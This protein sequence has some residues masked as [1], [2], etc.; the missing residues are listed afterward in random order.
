MKKREE[1]AEKYKWDLKVFYK[2]D[3]EFEKDIKKLDTLSKKLIKL[4]GKISTSPENIIES[5]NLL[6]EMERIGENLATYT[7]M[8]LDLDTTV[9]ESQERKS[10]IDSLVASIQTKISFVMPEIMKAPKEIRDALLKDKKYSFYKH[11][12]KRIFDQAKHIL[13]QEEEKILAAYSEVSQ[14]PYKVFSML[15]NADLKFE[16]AKD[17]K[18]KDHEVTT[19][20][21]VLHM[22]NEDRVLRKNAYT[23]I[24]NGYIDHINTLASTLEGILKANVTE[25]KLRKYKSSL[26]ASLSPNKIPVQVYENLLKAISD[27]MDYHK[28][29]MNTK[30]RILKLNDFSFYDVYMPLIREVDYKKEYDEAKEI[31]LKALSVLGDKY[32]K[33]AT[34]GLNNR[35]VDVY[36]TKG[37]RSGAYSWGTYDTP[38]LMLLN[39]QGTLD[40]VFTLAHELGHSMHSYFSKT[41]QEHLYAQYPIFLAEI[42]STVNEVLL[43]LH[44]L[45]N[46]DDESLKLYILN[47]FLEGFKSTVYRQTMFAEFEK[48]VYEAVENGEGL[49][50]QKLNN[51]YKNILEKYFGDTIV[52]DDKIQSEWSRIPHFYYNYYVYQY[53]IGFTTAVYIA[54]KIYEGDAKFRDNY[55]KFLSSGGKDYP[56]NILKK[57]VKIDLTS[58]EIIEESLDYFGVMLEKFKSLTSNSKDTQSSLENVDGKKISIK[59]FKG[60]WVVLYFYPKDNTSGCTTEAKEFTALKK[61][62]EKL[63]C[64]IIGVS[65]DTCDKHKKFIE[66]NNLNITL[67]C[68][69]EHLLINEYGV[70][71]KKKNYGKEYMGL[72]RSTFLLDKN[73][74]VVKKWKNVRAKGHAEKVLKALREIQ[75]K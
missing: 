62:F 10:K 38:P 8:S 23:S 74:E 67:L 51:T 60:K 36:E 28:E 30:K 49:S 45:D 71:Q 43:S 9:G 55:I 66:K 5:I 39:Y 35:W 1:I 40:S 12:L 69:P 58:P 68:D 64:E 7:A 44:L 42:A 17:S 63:D 50:S 61:E 27:K 15:N 65:P 16:K 26:E 32:V 6:D 34:N 47:H 33:I 57:T 54:K 22:E 72:V 53:A 25:S 41:T 2:N 20:N 46:T 3:K 48:T 24:Y 4:K 14:T 13:T 11:A 37:K 18:G 31:V 19:G 75:S 73:G 56:I 70:W 59:D 52:I 21:F 29:Y